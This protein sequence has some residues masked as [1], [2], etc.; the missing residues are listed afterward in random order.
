MQFPADHEFTRHFLTCLIVLSS[1]DPNIVESAQKLT[2]R[3]HQMQS[4]TPQK[5]PKWFNPTNV[6]N[7]YVVLHE[8]SQGDISKLDKCLY[9]NLNISK[10]CITYL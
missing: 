5:L 8:G 1:N 6:L 7:S 9:I 4:V 3:V 2:Q 10:L